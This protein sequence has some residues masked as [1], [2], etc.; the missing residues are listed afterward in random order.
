MLD[1]S[2][3][4]QSIHTG[5]NIFVEMETL[6]S[7]RD[8]TASS[9]ENTVQ[10]IRMSVMELATDLSEGSGEESTERL[11]LSGSDVTQ[12]TNVLGENVF[13]STQDGDGIEIFSNV[14]RRVRR[15]IIS[16]HLLEFSENASDLET[17]LEIVVLVGV[18]ELDVFT[19]VEDDGMVL[20]VRF[21]VTENRV[22]GELHAELGSAHSVFHE[23]GVSVDE[24]R[25]DAWFVT[26]VL[27]G[28]LVK[29]GDL[30][31]GIGAEEEFGVFHFFLLELGVT[32]HRDTNLVLAAGHTFQF[33]FEFVGV[34][35]E[36]LDDFWV[37]NAVK[38]LNRTAV[39]HETGN[40][41]VKSLR[42]KRCP[43][44]CSERILRGGGLETDAV[45]GKVIDLASDGILFV[46][47]FGIGHLRGFIGENLG[48]LDEAI[49]FVGVK[50]L[51]VLEKGDTGV[52]IVFANDLTEGEKDLF[53]VVR[54]EDGESRHV[55]NG[56]RFGDRSRKRLGEEGDTT[57]GLALAREKLRLKRVILLRDEKG[58]CS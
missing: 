49:P 31:V 50:L 28:F 43:D 4:E 14:A 8:T 6:L 51:E 27:G 30:K 26:L 55:I 46:L 16:V 57:L 42:P 19:T 34:S 33:L 44:T 2:T 18:D 47:L 5:V 1:A 10:E 9:H 7:L 17:F 37:F 58:G 24:S 41:T 48:I 38:K 54:D 23:F 45:E 12:D 35:T 25:V 20:V 56:D 52:R 53:G 36:H 32:L 15:D 40:G 3:T 22:A 29:V 39:V 13:T 11:F 21:S